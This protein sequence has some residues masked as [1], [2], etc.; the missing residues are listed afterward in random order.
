[1]AYC[2][3]IWAR[4]KLLAVSRAAILP[5]W[6]SAATGMVQERISG[7]VLSLKKWARRS[8]PVLKIAGKVTAAEPMASARA[9]LSR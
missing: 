1:L 3:R 5:T 9:S 4:R 2:T 8:R 6:P 7:E